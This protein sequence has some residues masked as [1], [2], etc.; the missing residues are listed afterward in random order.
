MLF[1]YELTSR[2][3]HL[4][5]ASRRALFRNIYRG[6]RSLLCRHE[7]AV[8]KAEGAGLAAVAS[9]SGPMG[10]AAAG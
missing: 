2:H 8:W 9:P 1:L 4:A 10:A 6:F 7:S 5:A 3:F